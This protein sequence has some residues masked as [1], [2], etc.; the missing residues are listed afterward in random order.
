MND[1]E[2]QI[3]NQV[4]PSVAPLCAPNKFVSKKIVSASAFPAASLIEID[5]TTVRSK[6]TSVPREEFSRIT[7]QFEGFAMTKRECRDVFIAA[8]EAM[9]ALNFSRMSGQFIDNP[10]NP[11][12]ARY[13][14]RYE[15]MI[16]RDG[17]IYRIP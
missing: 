3:F 4:Y 11:E 17:N 14:A 10:G 2:V 9:I 6:Q 1:F 15:A 5:N 16:D 12:I 7:Y 13:V 8:D